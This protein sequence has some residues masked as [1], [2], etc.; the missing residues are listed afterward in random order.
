MLRISK[1]FGIGTEGGCDVM[2]NGTEGGSEPKSRLRG[3]CRG[4]P[5]AKLPSTFLFSNSR[6]LWFASTNDGMPPCL[7]DLHSCLNGSFLQGAHG[8][9]VAALDPTKVLREFHCSKAPPDCQAHD[10]TL[11][12]SFRMVARL[13][14]RHFDELGGPRVQ[15]ARL[16]CHQS[17]HP[18]CGS[19]I[20]L[21][22]Q[23]RLG[24]LRRSR[25]RRRGSRPAW[26]TGIADGIR[27]GGAE[28]PSAPRRCL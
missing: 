5:I 20:L 16:R 17:M 19:N 23:P 28:S 9:V 18:R 2:R 6:Q 12:K 26:P 24:I 1:V 7:P 27:A 22:R 13:R 14:A 3:S 21:R 25:S 4:G 11:G 10:A 8:C 15:F